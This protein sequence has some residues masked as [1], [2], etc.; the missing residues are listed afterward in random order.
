MKWFKKKVQPVTSRA[1]S[2]AAV[3][4]KNPQ[5]SVSKMD[6]GDLLLVY[7]VTVRPL[8]AGMIKRLGG[9]ESQEQVKKLQLDEM[10]T[11]TW[12][13]IDGKRSVQKIAD[14]MSRRYQLMPQEAQVSVTAFLRELGRRGLIALK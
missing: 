5:V 1:E 8:L 2:L 7:T 12:Q 14:A 11:A 13:L 4:V 10:G 6:N 9:P 3:P